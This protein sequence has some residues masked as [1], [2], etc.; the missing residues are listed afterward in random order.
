MPRP[1]FERLEG[2]DASLRIAGDYDLFWRAMALGS[3][4]CVLDGVLVAMRVGGASSNTA[5]LATRI[6]HEVEVIT[7]QFR[8]AGALAAARGHLIR[9]CRFARTRLRQVG[10]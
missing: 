5:P 8:H 10:R 2:F 9:L 3:S 7:I 1:L 4:V 6:R